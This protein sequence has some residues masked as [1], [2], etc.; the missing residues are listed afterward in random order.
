MAG[1]A[2]A[3]MLEGQV[4]DMDMF[5][6]IDAAQI[7]TQHKLPMADSIIFA[8]CRAYNATLWTQDSDF[9]DLPGVRYIEKK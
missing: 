6:A 2:G 9:K 5:I 1:R 3:I 7:P 4:V 8:T